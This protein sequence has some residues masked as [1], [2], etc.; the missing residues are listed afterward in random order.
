MTTASPAECDADTLYSQIQRAVVVFLVS[1]IVSGIPLALIEYLLSRSF[2]FKEVN[3]DQSFVVRMM[4]KRS[5][6]S[7][8]MVIMCIAS[9][10]YLC[11]FVAI[12]ST[13]SQERWLTS[14]MMSVFHW[15]V[16][17]PVVMSVLY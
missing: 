7:I 6:A 15:L 17:G 4:L 3:Q 11:L 14:A 2:I 10:L 12:T 16:T 13:N 1:S 8:V 9:V 5:T